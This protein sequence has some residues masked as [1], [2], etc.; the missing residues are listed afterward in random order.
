MGATGWLNQPKSS[1]AWPFLAHLLQ[2]FDPCLGSENLAPRIPPG[3]AADPD[4]SGPAPSTP[5]RPAALVT[6][7]GKP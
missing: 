6:S 5:P 4:P 3:S 2:Q 7:Q 1:E